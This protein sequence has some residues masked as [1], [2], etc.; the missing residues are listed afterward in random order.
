MPVLV[1]GAGLVG[2]QIARILV[3]DGENPVLMDP[4]AQPDAIA[5]VVALDAV[6][7]VKGSVLRP[8]EISRV[9]IEHGITDIIHTAANPLL[10]LGAQSDPL[11]AIELNIMGTVNVFE[12]ARAHK[13]RRVVTSSSTVLNHY[14]EGGVGRG[15]SLKEEA[16][17]RP[18]TFYAATK[19]AVESLGLNYARWCGVD[20]AA[21][22]YGAVCGPWSGN[23]GG[24]PS[25]MFR[26]V[27]EGALS[28]E[29]TKVPASDMEWVYSKD[30]ALGTVLALRAPDL[31]T[32]I[33][34]L[35]MG[36]ITKPADFAKAIAKAIP[37]SRLELQPVGEVDVSMGTQETVS[38]PELA[39]EVLGFVPQYQIDEA[40]ADM[41][42][43]L[44]SKVASR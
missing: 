40:V 5:E 13:L 8:V 11:S 36:C 27:I 41:A 20:F 19:Q 32:R 39:R 21:M 24:G 25:N 28:G 33:F 4:A 16:Y 38:D 29:A 34:N 42:I 17:P 30:A 23:G 9:I 12:A 14:M 7:L 31:K 6:N 44:R 43:W 18:T 35:T 10:T 22:R 2:S 3:E 1:I 26:G 15:Q 37:E